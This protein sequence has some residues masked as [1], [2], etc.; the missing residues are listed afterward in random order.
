MAA[1][2]AIGPRSSLFSHSFPAFYAC[3]LLKSIQSPRSRV[4]YIGSTPSP[5]RR[6]RQHNGEITQGA[7]K[8]RFKRPWVM[9]MIVYGFPSKLAALQFEWA[10]QHPHISRHLRDTEGKSLFPTRSLAHLKK[11]INVVRTM[12]SSHPFNRW[13]LHIKLFTEEAVKCWNDATRNAV[14]PLPPGFMYT[15]ELEGV[16]GKSGHP[17][18]GR[19]G[20]ISVKDEHFTSAFLAKN[21]ALLASGLELKC[22]ICRGLLH[23]YTTQ[24]PLTTALCPTSTCT[25]VSHLSCMSREFLNA[26]TGY[27]GMIPRGGECNSC[28]S[29]ILWGDV[30]RGCYRRATNGATLVSE[31]DD[32]ELQEE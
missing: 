5:P 2:L 32:V 22:Y 9:Q 17:G 4:T 18:S 12:V 6:I 27:T 10:W 14:V 28:K 25:S 13:P 15:I 30:I 1:K 3:Y 19:Q 31:D 21:T 11:D 8:T 23:D 24:N 29:Y 16:D 7:Q 20:P 26:E